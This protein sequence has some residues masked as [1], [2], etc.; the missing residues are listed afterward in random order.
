M[1]P[2]RTAQTILKLVITNVGILGRIYVLGEGLGQV[3]PGAWYSSTNTESVVQSTVWLLVIESSPPVSDKAPGSV[4]TATLWV[5]DDLTKAASQPSY[6]VQRRLVGACRQRGPAKQSRG[7]RKPWGL[8]KIKK[9]ERGLLDK[10]W[11]RKANLL[12]CQLRV[13]RNSSQLVVFF[14]DICREQG[15][16]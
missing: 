7:H 13:C 10:K 14:S 8:G 6:R 16:R 2:P 15:S 11:A 9:P 5:M 3:I 4:G 12:V 1:K